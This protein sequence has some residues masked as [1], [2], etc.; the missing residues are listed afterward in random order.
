MRFEVMVL[1]YLQQQQFLYRLFFNVPLYFENAPRSQ[2]IY[3]LKRIIM[4][5][6]I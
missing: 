3:A 4:N 5:S 6:P 2:R 1:F